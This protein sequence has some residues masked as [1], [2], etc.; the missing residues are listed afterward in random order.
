MTQDRSGGTARFRSGLKIALRGRHDSVPV[1]GQRSRMS[2]GM[3]DLHTRK[4]VDLTI[5]LAR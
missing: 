1:A 5:R 2:G 4:V 3:G